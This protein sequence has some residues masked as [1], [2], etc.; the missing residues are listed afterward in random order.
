MRKYRDYKPNPDQEK[1]QKKQ[2]EKRKLGPD[3][4]THHEQ[5]LKNGSSAVTGEWV[6]L[7]SMEKP[8][9]QV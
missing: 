8:Q 4:N 9:I 5:T 6:T 7:D 1:R 2:S 3:A